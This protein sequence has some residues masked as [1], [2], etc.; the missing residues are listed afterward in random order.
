MVTSAVEEGSSSS[1]AL[2]QVSP[3]HPAL[4]AWNMAQPHTLHLL[5]LLGVD[6][7]VILCIRLQII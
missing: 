3:T 4:G 5:Y 1:M 6:S 7:G 2:P